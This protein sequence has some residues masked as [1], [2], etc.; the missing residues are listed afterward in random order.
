MALYTYPGF[1]TTATR[2]RAS[3]WTQLKET[4][5]ALR[6][7]DALFLSLILCFGAFHFFSYQRTPDFLFDDVFYAD[8]GRS[9][10][11]HGFY[12]INGH[13]ESNQPS[14]LPA[15]LGLLSLVGIAGHAALI[16]VMAACEALGLMFAYEVLRRE[17]P[18]AV[19]GSICLL[20]ASST[21]F[22][23]F[24]TR[25][26]F[27]SLPYLLTTMAALLVARNFENST[28]RAWKYSWG[29][30]LAV[31]ISVSLM[32][33]TAA[34]AFLGAIVMGVGMLYVRDRELAKTR[35][36]MYTPIFLIALM[37]L[38]S[39][40]FRKPGP[41]EWPLPGYP[42]SY[43]SQLALKSG[44]EPELGMATLADIPVR[45]LKN[46]ADDSI[47]LSEALYRRWVNV[48]WMSLLVTGPIILVLLGWGSSVWRWR[49]GLIEWY[50]IVYQLI[51]LLWPW[52]MEA[53]FFLPVMPLACLYLWRGS[54]TLMLLAQNQPRLLGVAS[55]P[56]AVI[57]AVSSW[58]W[59]Q[60]SWI[61]SHLTRVGLQDETSFIVWIVSAVLA[62]RMLWSENSW[63]LAAARFN[64]RLSATIP[65]LGTSGLGLLQFLGI[66]TVFLLVF[67]GFTSQVSLAR[68]N[69]DP[70]SAINRPTPD[71][72]AAQW[73]NA[74]TD[75]AAVIMA[76]HVPIVY[77]YA[78]RKLVWFPPSTNVS[79][80]MQGIR[81]QKVDY[82][83]SVN[84]QY[85]YYF[86]PDGIC[87]AAVLAAYPD[88]LELV[89]QT[90]EFRVFRVVSGK[91]ASHGSSPGP[92]AND[93]V[94]PHPLAVGISS[95]FDR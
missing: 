60:G 56:V 94:P 53:R 10:I 33:A 81:R 32:F 18:R 44:N 63:K 27:P 72:V 2:S 23:S 69:A 86:P 47:Q 22:F 93:G 66:L 58:F 90:P 67:F 91:T 42:H 84:R 45:I 57:L 59:M 87:I 29:F 31:L 14:G 73:V 12:G 7:T 20:L 74:N 40:M 19:A 76:R 6:S 77:H 39:W 54:K 9:L 95:T 8:A 25:S 65:N 85:N 38:G 51:Y 82:I 79:M 15:L 50:F 62:V 21:V 35:L 26:I 3:V 89:H 64:S 92:P 11:A 28:R 83:V 34:M 36:K 24:A 52:K 78:E 71:V 75:S 48:A 30:A 37:V 46:A 4:T 55:Y 1:L 49:G 5:S 43:F 68:A 61:G 41:T 88:A 80:L 16:R 70:S 13:P 17:V